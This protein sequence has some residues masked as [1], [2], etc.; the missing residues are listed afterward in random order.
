[1]FDDILLKYHAICV[2][3]VRQL[4][5]TQAVGTHTASRD[6]PLRSSHIQ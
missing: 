1:V 3:I 5:A 4:P 2:E 6:Q